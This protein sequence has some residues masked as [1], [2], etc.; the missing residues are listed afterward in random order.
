ML[1]GLRIYAQPKEHHN[2]ARHG[3]HSGKGQGAGEVRIRSPVPI[4]TSPASRVGE[5]AYSGC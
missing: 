3:I 1:D 2:S 4:L 5:L